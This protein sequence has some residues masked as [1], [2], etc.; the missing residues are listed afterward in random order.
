MENKELSE[1]IEK[2]LLSLGIGTFLDNEL[3]DVRLS[4]MGKDVLTSFEKVPEGP[5]SDLYPIFIDLILF[6]LECGSIGNKRQ[7]E[8]SSGIFRRIRG[9]AETMEI[10]NERLNR[11]EK[12]LE[13]YD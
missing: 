6:L 11:I 8:I 4:K 10:F 3:W 13:L 5:F 12:E 9:F 7:N 1:S 2:M